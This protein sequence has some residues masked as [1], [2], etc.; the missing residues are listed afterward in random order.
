MLGDSATP[1]ALNSLI[2]GSRA[3][4]VLEEEGDDHAA[5]LAI[6]TDYDGQRGLSQLDMDD[7]DVWLGWAVTVVSPPKTTDGTRILSLLRHACP[8][9]VRHVAIDIARPGPKTR[10]W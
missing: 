5:I 4:V 3:Q 8:V 1:L 6:A 10:R 9:G 7:A 2:G